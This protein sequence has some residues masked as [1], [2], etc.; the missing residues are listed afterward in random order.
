MTLK[1]IVTGVLITKHNPNIQI[2]MMKVATDH[3]V[4][5]HLS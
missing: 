3:G 4:D 2:V 1:E 5:T